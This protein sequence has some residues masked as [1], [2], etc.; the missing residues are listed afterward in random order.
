[1]R[2]IF[3]KIFIVI[4]ILSF[5]GSVYAYD[6]MAGNLYYTITNQAE[7]LVEVSAGDVKY[8]GDVVI[9]N[10][11]MNGGVTYTVSE[12]GWLVFK[13]STEL[14]S[15]VLNDNIKE[16]SA[17][18]FEDCSSL[19]SVTL[20][21][22]L[23]KIEGRAFKNCTSL[24]SINLND[25]IVELG[26]E[27]FNGCCSLTHA[28][29][30]SKVRDM[31]IE[32]FRGCTN[33][34][35]VEIHEGA[36][37]IG[38]S[39]FV[40][41]QRLQTVTIPNSVLTLGASIFQHCM[42]LTEVKIGNGVLEI[43]SFSFFDCPQLRTLTFG[44]II[45]KVNSFRTFEGTTNIETLTV[46]AAE[47]PTLEEGTFPNYYATLYVP[48]QSVAAYQAH[49]FWGRFTVKPI[50]SQ[51][52]L[53]IR[54]GE[55]GTIKQKVNIGETYRYDII[56]DAGWLLHSVTFNNE[57]VTM[58]LVDGT[59]TTPAMTENGILSIVY[60]QEGSDVRVLEANSV[61]V[62][63]D[64]KGNIRISNLNIGETVS[65]YSM[66]GDLIHQFYA[67]RG[68]EYLQM[69]THG[70]YVVKVGNRSFKINI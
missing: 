36:S 5:T 6:F 66:K 40:Y 45:N 11:V 3:A 32:V 58:Q 65:I 55:G 46:L 54:Q 8:S 10:T 31:G 49:E 12:I 17:N 2:R 39:T 4:A 19:V 35:T 50:D 47:P 42:S 29:I 7:K 51:I 61:R 69:N 56:P 63:G 24:S 15:I 37:V 41:C 1:M 28:V 62:T 23:E 20:G 33:L 25:N 18:E 70:V 48:S 16:I 43:P 52:Y 14:T 21:N 57:D 9:P 59:Y 26:G 44:S 60:E 68:N 64:S 53:T 67:N 34:K 27:A 30:G 13:Q 38:E 22:K